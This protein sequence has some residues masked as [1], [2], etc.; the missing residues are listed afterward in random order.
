MPLAL[1]SF[2]VTSDVFTFD[3]CLAQRSFVYVYIWMRT[4]SIE[5]LLCNVMFSLYVWM[6]IQN[7]LC[8]GR[9]NIH[10][11]NIDSF[12]CNIYWIRFWIQL[13]FISFSSFLVCSICEQTRISSM[14][15]SFYEC[16]NTHQLTF[17][18]KRVPHYRID[19]LFVKH[20]I[21]YINKI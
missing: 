21:K 5:I 12:C 18:S 10:K 3:A 20:K 16:T 7:I 9:R 11:K 17:Y 2:I 14:N 15:P 1:C 13:F 4:D 8:E 6:E 19:L